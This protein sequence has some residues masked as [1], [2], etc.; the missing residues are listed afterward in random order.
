MSSSK[1]E[2]ITYLATVSLFREIEPKFILTI[3]GKT[4][5]FVKILSEII[6]YGESCLNSTTTTETVPVPK[7][8]YLVPLKEYTYEICKAIISQI[9]LA[10]LED[11]LSETKQEVYIHSFLDFDN[12]LSLQAIGT[13]VKFLEKNWSLFDI[14]EKKDLCYI[15]INQISRKNHLLID[16]GTFKALQI[17]SKRGHEAGFKRGAQSSEREGLSIFKLFSMNCKSKLGL[18][19]LKNI[20]LNPLNNVD[21]LNKRLDF[22]DFVLNPSNREF[23]ESLRDNLKGI[24][25]DINVILTRIENSRAKLRDWHVLYKT[26]THTIFMKDISSP[27]I[28]H[29]SLLMDLHEKVSPNLLRLED[30]I[31]NGLD[32]DASKKHGK[33]VIK[34]GLDNELDKKK[35]RRQ[36]ITND[37]MAAARFAADNL[38]DFLDECSVVYIPEMGHLLSIKEWETDCSPEDLEHLGFQFMFKIGGRIHYKNAMCIE[39]N[40]RLGDTIL[41]IIDHE[42]RIMRRLSGFIIKYNKDIREPLKVVGLIDCLISMA[43]SAMIKLYKRPKLN[44]ENYFELKDCRHPLMEEMIEQFQTNDFYSGGAHSRMKIITGPNS[45]GKSVYLKQILLIIYMGHVG[46]FVPCFSADINL[47]DTMY[48]RLQATESAAVRLSSFMID[49]TQVELNMAHALTDNNASSLVFLDEFA[50]GTTEAEGI[51]LLEGALKHFLDRGPNCPHV[52][53]VTHFQNIH[54]Y[55]P[56]SPSIQYQKMEHTNENGVLYFLYKLTEGISKSF[57][58]DV[59][60]ALGLD[61]DVIE[62][63]RSIFECIANETSISPLDKVTRK[64]NFDPHNLEIINVCV[65]NVDVDVNI[66]KTGLNKTGVCLEEGESQVTAIESIQESTSSF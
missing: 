8:L 10:V 27:Y 51:S 12:R 32:F 61:K 39:L 33:P 41:E 13:L 52:I 56:E 62:R 35:L 36:D 43:M 22:I 15:H 64:N 19:T 26:I 46:S 54:L 11:E 40:K 59:A 29:C 23:V 14:S 24:A 60:E 63:A 17:F 42:N 34:Y 5:G 37:V 55:L 53:N 4:E 2:I 7:N 49:L 28:E 58:I 66:S 50:K 6:L 57:A 65:D 16:N 21:I 20:L 38:P 31:T 45:S 3:G 48:T 47:L 9:K 30:S 25:G 1:T 18:T 44:R